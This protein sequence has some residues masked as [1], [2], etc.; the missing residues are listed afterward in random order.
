MYFILQ[1]YSHYS[2][3]RALQRST[4]SDAA[5]HF[6]QTMWKKSSLLLVRA[7]FVFGSMAG[8]VVALMYWL[9]SK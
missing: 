6:H 5:K 3:Y 2:H 4:N 9:A 1:S 7:T 8:G